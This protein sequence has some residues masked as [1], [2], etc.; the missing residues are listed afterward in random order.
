MTSAKK[1]YKFMEEGNPVCTCCK[2]EYWKGGILNGFTIVQTRKEN[3]DDPNYIDIPLSEIPH[4][5]KIAKKI[6][7]E[8]KEL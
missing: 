5:I 4:L 1:K 3:D 7:K 6:M 8:D 2:L